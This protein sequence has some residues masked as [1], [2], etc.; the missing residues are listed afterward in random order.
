MSSKTTKDVP[1]D[2]STKERFVATVKSYKGQASRNLYQEQL[3]LL[4]ETAKIYGY[5]MQ[6]GYD[7]G[8]GLMK[9]IVYEQN[10]RV[11]EEKVQLQAK[12]AAD[13]RNKVAKAEPEKVPFVASEVDVV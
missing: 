12:K 10:R 2:V 11:A 6:C 1:F 4:I 5:S 3:N 9:S 7:T 8:I 13:L